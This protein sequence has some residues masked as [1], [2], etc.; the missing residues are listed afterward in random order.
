MTINA[1]RCEI[2]NLVKIKIYAK[3]CTSRF[4]CVLCTCCEC[5]NFMGK[6]ENKWNVCKYDTLTLFAI[7]I[8][9][10]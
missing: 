2:I 3:L 9:Q 1:F 10:Q 6:R 8:G 4:I 7:E 5:L